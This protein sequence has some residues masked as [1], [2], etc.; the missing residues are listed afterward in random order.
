MAQE[1]NDDVLVL[2]GVEGAFHRLDREHRLSGGLFHPEIV[3]NRIKTLVLEVERLLLWL[4][5]SHGSEVQ[6]LLNLHGVVERDVERF[7]IQTDVLRVLLDIVSFYVFDMQ[8]DL[9]DELLLS[10]G[11][12]LD[13]HLD[14]LAR[15]Q[16][17]FSW[18]YAEFLGELLYSCESPVDGYRAVI[19]EPEV[20]LWIF[21]D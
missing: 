18:R 13:M 2:V 20:L 5:D 15:L 16:H 6:E 3:L 21:T 10:F 4:S 19:L 11:V 8:L 7:G 1:P 17:T 14:I 9:L 12:E